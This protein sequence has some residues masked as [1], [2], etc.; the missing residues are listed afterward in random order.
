[1]GPGTC[2]ATKTFPE[3]GWFRPARMRISVVLPHPFS[4]NKPT[5]LLFPMSTETS[6]SAVTRPYCFV[7]LRIS[8]MCPPAFF[9]QPQSISSGDTDTGEPRNNFI[10][11]FLR[12]FIPQRIQEGF[13]IRHESS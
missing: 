8:I 2:P 4:P 1:L 13:L 7:R 3:L 12:R 10:N 6:S 9:Y 5:I 11:N